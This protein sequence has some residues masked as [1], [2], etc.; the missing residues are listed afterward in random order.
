MRREEKQEVTRQLAEQLG[1]AETI[2][3]TDFTGLDVG[4]ITE[5]RNRL[6]DAGLQYRV[7]KNTLMRRAL[8]E[9][10]LPDIG[11]HLTGPTGLV[12]GTDDP[13]L[14][15][16]V[17]RDFAKEHEER[18]TVK[19]GIVDRR[20]VTP[21]EVGAL[22]AVPPYEQLL[23]GIA[24]GLTASAGGIVGILAG[25]IRDIACMTEEVARRREAG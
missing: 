7:V 14:P 10:D 5:L 18:P 11:E 15:A 25:L 4:S 12:L 19:I 24:G 17:V 21:E 16:K 6:S 22:A 1:G 20:T 2:Y 3:L 13:V 8:E 9:L 23:A